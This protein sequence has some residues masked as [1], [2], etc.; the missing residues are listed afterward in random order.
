MARFGSRPAR[1]LFICIVT[2]LHV[3]A[4]RWHVTRKIVRERTS[5]LEVRRAEPRL[6]YR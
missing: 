2:R 6:A 1:L 5:I 4:V 3:A